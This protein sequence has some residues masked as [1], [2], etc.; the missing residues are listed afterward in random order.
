MVFN[1]SS[2]KTSSNGALQGDNP[3]DYAFP[4]LIL[5]TFLILLVSRSLAFLLKPLRQPKVI[6]EI[7]GGILLGPSAFGRNQTYM[8]RIFPSWSTPILES[9]AS[10]GL[11]FFLF[12]VGLELDL[13]SIRRSGRRAFAIAASGISVPFIL[14]IGVA[15]LLRKTVDG[16]DKVGFGQFLVFMGVALSITAF[17]VL[18]RI[19]AELK[20]LTTQAGEIAMA[21]AAFN[22]VAAWILL[23][24]AIAIAGDGDGGHH[25]SPLVSVWV[26]LSGA[27]FVIFMMVAIRPAMKWVALRC[28]SEHEA[29]HEHYI[30]LTLAGVMVSGFMTDFIGIHSIFGAF[31]FGL[32]IPKEGDFAE[33]LMERIEDFVSGL[34]LPLY[35]AS[36]GLK[37]DVAKIRGGEAWGLLAL[38]ITTACAGKILGTFAVAMM[39]FIPAR[40]S[41]TLGVLMNTKGLVE[42]IVLNIGKEKKVLN[43]EMFAI[44]VLMALFTTFITTPTVM[45]IY[46]PAR[47]IRART[48]R[49]LGDLSSSSK[50]KAA[51]ELRVLAC[52]HGPGNVPSIIRLIEL[53]R[54][55]NKSLLKLFI[56]HLVELTERSSSIVLAQRARKDGFPFFN[57]F[58]GGQWH[59]RLA[60]AFQAYSQCGRVSVRPSTAISSLSTMHEDIRHMAEQ[61][62]VTMIILP[63]HKQW[64]MEVEE[65]EIGSGR[66]EVVENVGHGWRGVNQRVLK[67]SPCS[68]AVLIDRGYGNRSGTPPNV[69][70]R[71]C[72]LFFGGPDD[73]EAMELGGRMAEHTAVKVAVVRFVNRNGLVGDGIVLRPSL[74]NCSEKNYSFSTATMNHEKEK[75]LDE[76][77]VE[78]FRRKWQTAVYIEKAASNIVEEV[79]GMGR[80]GDYDL[81]VV[82][83]GRF[84]SSMV[85][86]LAGRQA[87]HAELGPIGDILASSGQGVLSSVLVI[88]QPDVELEDESPVSKV[89]AEYYESSVGNEISTSNDNNV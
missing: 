40:E 63:F 2:I 7:V 77:A 73:R 15:M 50:K 88:Q 18:A 68:V 36:S 51:G 20:L 27:A 79:L 4:L 86:E 64:R 21:A 30:C 37:T 65:E 66:H 61:K 49:R 26:L 89:L 82:G 44:L 9:V 3:L 22:D 25:K 87:E 84:P 12:L 52:V 17:P 71:V 55:T 54:S 14:G 58:H 28:S 70:Q 13:A 43:D 5:Q 47:G 48:H 81:I 1:I 56:M 85:V 31:V 23:A 46:K 62:R 80:S 32:T 83:K 53:T 78:E 59:D 42:L 39:C 57:R 72:I 16:A 10:I 34:L 33:R 74:D 6:A 24:L 75:G 8:H 41:L 35:F 60:G 69:A 11:L 29:V 38:V 67:N 76:T 19:L 45:A